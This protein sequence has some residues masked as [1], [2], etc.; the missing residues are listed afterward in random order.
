ME[1]TIE[2]IKQTDDFI[3]KARLL[4]K[5]KKEEQL[6]T[7]DLA[8]KAGLKPSYLCH[9]LRLNRLPDIV[10]DGY[11]SKTISLSH[12]FI[13]SRIKD[14]QQIIDTYEKILQKSL[15]ISETEELVREIMHGIKTT[16]K[17]LS[18]KRIEEFIQK[19]KTIDDEIKVK[20]LQSRLKN[21]ILIEIN[22]DLSYTSSVLKKII[23]RFG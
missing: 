14:K 8:E 12:L 11:Y 15:T 22:G 21:K 20:V 5:L 7:K 9:I 16:G 13:I 6:M 18:V 4:L 10:I 19:I 2:K 23:E 17:Y 1:E 3:Y